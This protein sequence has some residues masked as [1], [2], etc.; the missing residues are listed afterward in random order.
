[1]LKK[2][3]I[4]TILL[5][6]VAFA[7]ESELEKVEKL[8]KQYLRLPDQREVIISYHPEHGDKGIYKVRVFLRKVDAILWD[9][10]FSQE[11]KELWTGASFIPLFSEKY[12]ED[13]D[14]DGFLEIAIAVSHG[15]Q[16]VWNTPAIIFKVKNDG[17]EFLK[18]QQI[19]DEFSRSVYEKKSDFNDPSYLCKHCQ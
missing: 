18:K 1:M 16:A 10:T 8:R 3:L 4:Y 5:L 13:L 9:K 17:L 19:N 14:N 2:Y 15:G 12:Y 11:Y 7:D 6:Q